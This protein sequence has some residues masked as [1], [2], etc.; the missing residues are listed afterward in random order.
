M[1][2]LNRKQWLLGC[3]GVALCILPWIY[4]TLDRSKS[5]NKQEHTL[6]AGECGDLLTTIVAKPKSIEFVKCEVIST[7]DELRA[8]YRVPGKDAVSVEKFLQ[9][10]FGMAQLQPICCG[11][12]PVIPQQ[13][14]SSQPAP[15]RYIDRHGSHYEITL[16][17][18]EWDIDGPSTRPHW[19][20]KPFFH[21][22]V[23]KRS[24]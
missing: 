23:R 17:S 1:V 3:A 21:L 12:T 19:R 4:L 11:W 20:K 24:S 22:E 13:I 7:V 5:A 15:G 8:S 18:G 9:H 16:Y 6:V 14:G 10:Q 2:K